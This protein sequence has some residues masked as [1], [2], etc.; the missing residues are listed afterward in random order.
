MRRATYPDGLGRVEDAALEIHEWPA[1]L[2]SPC[3]FRSTIDRF[4]SKESLSIVSLVSRNCALEK[5][6][7]L[8]LQCLLKKEI[9]KMGDYL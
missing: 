1:I 6:R 2:F 8:L 3:G 7:K 9:F 5:D 4:R